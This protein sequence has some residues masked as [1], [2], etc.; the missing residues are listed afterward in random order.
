MKKRFTGLFLVIVLTISTIIPAFAM[1]G[2][3]DL[4]E[5]YDSC[6]FEDG[7]VLGASILDN[8]NVLITLSKD[9]ILLEAT[10][11]DYIRKVLLFTD[12]SNEGKARCTKKIPFSSYMACDS[13]PDKNIAIAASGTYTKFGKVS[14]RGQIG[15]DFYS[16]PEADVYV[17]HNTP[18]D[19]IR[20]TVHVGNTSSVTSLVGLIVSA[21]AMKYPEITAV[22]SFLIS[23]GLLA[24]DGM[25]TVTVD[26]VELE[27]KKYGENIKAVYN[28]KSQEY[29]EGARFVTTGNIEENGKYAN[30]VFYDG[31]CE[32][33]VRDAKTEFCSGIY[34]V[35]FRGYGTLRS[36]TFSKQ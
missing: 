13:L 20:Q 31:L 36:M 22:K 27:S 2:T 12:A 9:N 14:F 8:G 32:K 18:S 10:E 17:R 26:Y 35:F 16:T 21:L 1:H 23:L 28:G 11:I 15:I 34:N 7:S 5:C 6:S 3:A 33:H 4:P 19:T 24:A 25:L 30:R 29:T